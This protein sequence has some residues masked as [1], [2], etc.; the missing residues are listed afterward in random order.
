MIFIIQ[1]PALLVYNDGIFTDE[2]LRSIQRI[3][4]SSVTLDVLNNL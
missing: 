4:E 1:G 3:G 2:D